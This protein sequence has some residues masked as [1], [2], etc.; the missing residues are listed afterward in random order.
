VHNT[1]FTDVATDGSEQSRIIGEAS[2]HGIIQGLNNQFM[3]SKPV[4][5]GE[6]TKILLSSSAYFPN[7]KP[8]KNLQ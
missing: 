1:L 6:L 3:P 2:A 7:G 5:V 4:T 8:I